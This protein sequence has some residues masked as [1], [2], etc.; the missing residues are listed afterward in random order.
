M[1]DDAQA[2]PVT[3]LHYLTLCACCRMPNGQTSNAMKIGAE[4]APRGPKEPPH[5]QHQSY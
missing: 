1:E 5:D 2:S 4:G 3:R